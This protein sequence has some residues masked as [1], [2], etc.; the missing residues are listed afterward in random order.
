MH[1]VVKRF[2]FSDEVLQAWSKNADE[3]KSC[4]FTHVSCLTVPTCRID[5]SEQVYMAQNVRP[6]FLC[7]K[8]IF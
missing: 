7:L 4:I 2:G 8:Y 5:E 1:A 6:I 3:G